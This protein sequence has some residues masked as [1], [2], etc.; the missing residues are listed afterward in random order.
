MKYVD[1][2]PPKI[3]S[4]IPAAASIHVPARYVRGCFRPRIAP[5]GIMKQLLVRERL[6]EF[7]EFVAIGVS[8]RKSVK[9]VGFVGM[10]EPSTH[11]IV[12]DHLIES[13]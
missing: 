13:R 9:Y 11:G 12:V 1:S 8:Q 7:H 3:L 10:V 2:R 4:R 5:A 6:Q